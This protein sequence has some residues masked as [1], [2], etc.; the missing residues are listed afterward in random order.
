MA[1]LIKTSDPNGLLVD[2]KKKID[3]HEIDTWSYDEDN[4]FTHDVPQWARKAWIRP[5]IIEAECQIVFAMVGR[6]GV[7]MTKEVYSLF[8]GRFME[9]LLKYYANIVEEMRILLPLRNEYDVKN[10]D[11]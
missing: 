5:Y 6:K 10:V 4:D 1:I 11:Y 9:M 7:V 2:I 3:D 8:Q